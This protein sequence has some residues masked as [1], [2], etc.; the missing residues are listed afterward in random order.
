M[1]G[2][3]VF[4][5]EVTEALQV[6]IQ[7]RDHFQLLGFS[8]RFQVCQQDLAVLL[9]AVSNTVIRIVAPLRQKSGG[10]LPC[11]AGNPRAHRCST[12]LKVGISCLGL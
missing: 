9:A 3:D 10:H 1:P 12:H 6:A 11:A 5:L 8:T 7:V 4:G 2:L